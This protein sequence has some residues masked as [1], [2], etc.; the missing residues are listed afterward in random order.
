MKAEPIYTGTYKV[1]KVFRK[2]GR[3]EV[4]ER[5]LTRD[6]AKIVVN[7]YPDSFRS[8]VIFCKQFTADKYFL[9]SK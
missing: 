2:S 5:N 4:I 3:R 7:R 6:E 9:T 8:M 1:I